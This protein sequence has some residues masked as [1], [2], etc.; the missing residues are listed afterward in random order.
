M[1]LIAVPFVL[2]SILALA[3]C[4]PTVPDS[5]AGVL[6]PFDSQPPAPGT[7][8]TG[9]PLVPPAQISTESLPSASGR[10]AQSVADFG[11]STPAP[12][13][14]VPPNQT[15]TVTT[16]SSD[17]IAREAAAAL[18]AAQDNS[19]VS[20]VQASPSNPAPQLIG[21]PGISDENDFGAVS[22]R[23]SIESDAERLQR[24]REQFEQVAPT[25]LPQRDGAG[26]PN[27]VR[28]ALATSHP[29]G[30][31]IYSRAGVNLRARSERNCAQFRS[32]DEAQTEFL[33][34]GG[35]ERDRKALDPDG[36][37]YA[38]GWD[39]RPFRLAVGNR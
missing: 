4:D 29:K 19:G 16:A 33:R 5:G 17:D 14:Y 13:P 21:N 37:G 28:F 38:C 3:A 8:I 12:T 15:R 23:Q 6:D 7:T 32:G 2:T 11:N 10:P 22:S 27:I 30:T 26:D 36:D 20:P 35:P 24:N 9:E 34:L 18:T 31:R 39:P 25:A 1:R